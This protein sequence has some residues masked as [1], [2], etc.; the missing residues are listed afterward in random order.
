[1]I[2]IERWLDLLS[3]V[4]IGGTV[5]GFF[6]YWS[7]RL[8]AHRL[9][10]EKPA[11]FLEF[12][13]K[14]IIVHRQKSKLVPLTGREQAAAFCPV[15]TPKSDLLSEKVREELAHLRTGCL[16]AGR[17]LLRA[18]RKYPERWQ[19]LMRAASR[20]AVVLRR[21]LASA[22]PAR[23]RRSIRTPHIG[24]RRVQFLNR[25]RQAAAHL[26]WNFDVY[27]YRGATALQMLSRK[28]KPLPERLPKT[29]S[30]H[31]PLELFE[32]PP[33]HTTAGTLKSRN[34]NGTAAQPLKASKL[35]SRNGNGTAAQPL[36]ASKLKSR[37]GNGRAAKSPE[38]GSVPTHK[39]KPPSQVSVRFV[40][41][42]PAVKAS[43][44]TTETPDNN[45]NLDHAAGDPFPAP[46]AALPSRSGSRAS[47]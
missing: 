34:G 29:P 1:M 26:Q 10:S 4:V 2:F 13:G 16:A 30:E 5:A 43:T 23:L 18:R 21:R 47:C 27:G 24:R 31:P 9:L 39:P 22:I 12:T 3:I 40:G 44:E 19:S 42:T 32:A 28:L 14:Q 20:E 36:K 8:S 6:Y 46:Q 7:K 35:K 25:I 17:S 45:R 41:P 33:P 11:T 37:N 15:E 38:A